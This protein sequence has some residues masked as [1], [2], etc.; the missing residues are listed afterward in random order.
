MV[1]GRGAL[2]GT[3]CCVDLGFMFCPL[4]ICALQCIL[5]LSAMVG[6]G[7]PSGLGARAPTS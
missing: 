1:V 4:A 6:G 2:I 3:L 7:I 5:V